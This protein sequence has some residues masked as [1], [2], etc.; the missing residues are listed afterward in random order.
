MA[1]EF[2]EHGRRQDHKQKFNPNMDME[3]NEIRERMEQLELRMQQEAKLHWRYKC[4][5]NKREKWPIQKVLARK[6]QK[7]L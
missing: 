5:L 1:T 4:P 6:K 2:H 3:L 7:E